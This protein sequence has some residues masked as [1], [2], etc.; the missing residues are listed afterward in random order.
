MGHEVTPAKS[1]GEAAHRVVLLQSIP[2]LEEIF[3]KVVFGDRS[4]VYANPLT[5]GDKM[6][7]GVETW[8]HL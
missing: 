2:D 6:R 1:D 7:R 3:G 4:T 8:G 5:D